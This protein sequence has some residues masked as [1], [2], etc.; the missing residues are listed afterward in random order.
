MGLM[1]KLSVPALA[2]TISAGAIAGG[3]EEKNAKNVVDKYVDF[4]E[5]NPTGTYIMNNS[6]VK[7]L[8]EG[9][10]SIHVGDN[11][12]AFKENSP[13]KGVFAY[14]IGKDGE[15]ER[16]IFTDG[17]ISKK[18]RAG[19]DIDGLGGEKGLETQVDLNLGKRGDNKE[20]PYNNRKIFDINEN[21]I[22]IYDFEKGR[23]GEVRGEDKTEKLQ[24][25]YAGFVRS[26]DDLLD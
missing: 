15:A 1:K 22:N 10:K 18:N 7:Y 11:Y 2:L 3:P 9:N 13:E 23:S 17:K 14:D 24:K 8:K 5:S 6:K 12:V 21:N 4:V 16:M 19:L 20:S 25:N 26:F